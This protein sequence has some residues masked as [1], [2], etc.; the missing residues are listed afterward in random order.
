MTKKFLL[1][2]WLDYIQNL[3]P[4]SIDLNLDRVRSVALNLNL[5]PFK[6]YTILIGG[7]N[8]KGTTCCLLEKILLSNNIRVG[9]YT[10]PHLLFYSERIRVCGKELS[11]SIHV[12]A[13][14]VVEDAR[15]NILLTY[16][17][18]ITL[19]AFYIFKQFKLDIV[20]L[21]VG[22]GGRLDATNIID[23]NI[24]VIT[25]IAIDHVN[26]LGSTREK[27]AIEKSGILRSN[28]P[29]VIGEI[30]RPK[31]IDLISQRLE[32][33]LFARNRDWNFFRYKNKWAWINYK[34][35]DKSLYNLPLP[36]VP[37]ENAALVLSVLY[38][39]P[40]PIFR[41]SICYG[42]KNANLLGRLQIINY[43][44]CIILDVGHNPN[45]AEYVIQ[46]LSRIITKKGTTRLVIGMLKDKD[47]QNTVYY[48]SKLIDVWYC[49][50]LNTPL[51]M[52]IKKLSQYF[53]NFDVKYF[54]DIKC[55]WNQAIMDV[56]IND[57][58]LVFGS[59]Y[60][61]SPIIKLIIDNRHLHFKL[62]PGIRM[63]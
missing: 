57:C 42:L 4:K 25:N 14:S 17:E 47:V 58:I 33:I 10:S 61:V 34:D 27:I 36:M 62:K 18:F 41:K 39:L 46:R 52:D 54:D 63:I 20:I 21:E 38:W 26:F 45:A 19:S 9:L 29:V 51:S 49:A 2:E 12:K 32:S 6:I 60:A 31:V 59:F 16:F 30:N 3:N 15:S 37:L 48:L 13:M 44:P 24:S 7:T 8:G 55:A 11:D 50:N 22:L 5:L 1:I 43:K 28:I 23:P 35:Y 40:F 53:V 56:K